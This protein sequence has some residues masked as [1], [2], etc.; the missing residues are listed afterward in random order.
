[1]EFLPN[2]IK[3]SFKGRI[4]FNLVSYC[5]SSVAQR[6]ATDGRGWYAYSPALPAASPS[7]PA[8]DRV[9]DPE[10]CE[11]KKAEAALSKVLFFES[12]SQL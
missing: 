11:K 3:L 8:K 10:N 12:C 5:N 1:M 6:I 9:L 4:N 2:C 7:A